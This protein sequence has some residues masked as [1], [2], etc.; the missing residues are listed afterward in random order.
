MLYILLFLVCVKARI[1]VYMCCDRIYPLP[2]F[3]SSLYENGFWFIFLCDNHFG[4]IEIFL[5]HRSV[6]LIQR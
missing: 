2:L 3:H 6:S 4:A 5:R 1:F